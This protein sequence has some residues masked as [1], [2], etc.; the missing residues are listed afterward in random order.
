[1]RKDEILDPLTNQP[2]LA[3]EFQA[4]QQSTQAQARA[5][6]ALYQ[7]NQV[8]IAVKDFDDYPHALE[9]LDAT[10]I[11]G[12]LT[13]VLTMSRATDLQRVTAGRSYFPGGQASVPFD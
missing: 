10:E 9:N 6:T 2:T 8:K 5:S 7:A 13:A 4:V 12:N 1:M 11:E 3:K